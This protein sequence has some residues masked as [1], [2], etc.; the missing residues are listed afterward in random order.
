VSL[1]DV[2]LACASAL[3]DE[4]VHGG[5]TQAC[6][7]PGSRSTPLALALARDERVQVHVHLDERSSAFFALGLAKF[8]ARPVAVACTSGT[9]AAEFWPAVVEASQSR[10]PLLLLTAD[11]PPRLRGTGANQTI[12]QVELY[13]RFARA[14]LEM[15]V[16]FQ[17]DD[18]AAWRAG[19]RDAVAASSAGIPGPVQVNCPFEEPLI[20]S[21][22]PVP[23]SA[24]SP[25]PEV[26]VGTAREDPPVEALAQAVDGRRGVVLMGASAR[27]EAGAQRVTLG[28]ALGW[29]VIAEPASMARR[30]GLALGAGQALLGST[31]WLAAHPPE[32]VVQVGALPTTRA[33]QGFA[34]RAERLV[35]VDAD[36]LEPDPQGRATLRIHQDI[37][38][39]GVPAVAPAPGAWLDAWR[40]ADVAARRTM[41]DLLDRSQAPTELQVARDTAAT[42]PGE[43]TLFVGNSMPVRDLDYAM[44]PRD[45]SRVLANRGASGIDGLVSTAMGI[46]AANPAPTVA[47]LG[48]LSLLY[49]AGA[50]LWNG[51]RASDLTIVVLNNGG[52]QI[53]ATLGQGALAPDELAGLF[54]TPHTVDL[55]TLCAAAGAAHTLVAEV[56]AFGPALEHAIARG[57]V[58]VFEVAV[59]PDRS[60][61]QRVQVQ[62]AVDAALSPLV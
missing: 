62:D 55:G 38:R 18:V 33:A 16:P 15:V 10:I 28:D 8:L 35:V 42:I 4:L 49:D 58:H 22:D 43:G 5:M 54:T 14:Y 39:L 51:R 44:A 7:S 52:G 29:P 60:R 21:T 20:P 2:S 6:V 48:D 27:P 3:V 59:D 53:F 57:G 41:D 25:G 23:R 12:D 19:G 61:A 30:P 17:E 31:R 32:V 13:G 47:L 34:A 26:S 45:G 1:G 46:A 9:A 50:L 24:S 36:H 11:R 40:L 56:S 37:S